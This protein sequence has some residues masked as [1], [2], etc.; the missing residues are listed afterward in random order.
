ML[1]L[2]LDLLFLELT[3]RWVTPLYTQVDARRF[4]ESRG[5]L[6]QVSGSVSPFLTYNTSY[7]KE[8]VYIYR[9]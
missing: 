3:R 5:R 4:T 1:D 6:I 7:M 9:P 2:V 8:S